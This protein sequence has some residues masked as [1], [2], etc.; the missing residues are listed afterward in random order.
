MI[1]RKW[2]RPWALVSQNQPMKIKPNHIASAALAL[3]T[4]LT[5]SAVEDAG[6]TGLLV[7]NARGLTL[8]ARGAVQRF[9]ALAV[10]GQGRVVAT[11]KLKNLQRLIPNARQLDAQGQI[12]MPG[13]A[14]AHGHVLGLGLSRRHLELRETTDL[15][16]ALA[17]IKSYAEAR[18][19]AS[20]IRG[21]GWNQANWKLGRFPT[22]VELD[23]AESLRP[24]W[25]VRVDG[26]AGW[27]NSRALALAGISCDTPDPKG[28][29]IERGADGTPSGILVDSAMDLVS[30]LVPA[31]DETEQR[32]A[33]LT[34][35]TELL[36]LGFT[37]VHDAGV[38][39]E[40]DV[41]MRELVASGE[42]KIRVKGMF[43]GGDPVMTQRMLSD[44]P[45]TGKSSFY[46]LRSVK[47]F[48][49]GALGSRGAA[50]IEPY[51]DAPHS[52]GLLFQSDDQLYAQMRAAAG[53]GF[54]VNVHAIGDAGNRQVL[55]NLERLRSDL[56]AAKTK[57]L[58]H[59]IEHAQVLALA[60]IP[61]LAAA[62]VVASIQ[63]VHATSDMNM[64]EDRVGAQRI[65]CAY[66]WQRLLKSGTRIACGSDFPV[67]EPTPWAGLHAAVTRQGAD[68]RPLGR[69]TPR[70]QADT[71]TR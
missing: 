60:D 66:A 9:D 19:A 46:N 58:R 34:A 22:A 33:L 26:H 16:A 48:A 41:L 36:S 44:G 42:L 6:S 40:T 59:R 53:A 29:S 51:S 28:G 61:R 32:A 56:G 12:L 5:V 67:E 50:L 25:L 37:G 7:H 4:S 18:P 65:Q 15:P 17:A 39:S 55:A 13:M 64:A 45:Y 27:A 21:R 54:Q 3:F 2:M 71:L 52:H 24:V 47:L 63:P 38:A 30:S 68:G 11:G 14:D 20:W 1:V 35:Q 23:S 49:D 70:L 57:A 69:W 31:T 10:D 8:D 62:D 43:S